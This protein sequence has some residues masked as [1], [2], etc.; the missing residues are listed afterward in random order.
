[1]LGPDNKPPLSYSQFRLL[2]LFV[3]ITVFCITNAFLRHLGLRGFTI[4]LVG[5]LLLISPLI[6]LYILLDLFH[7][8]IDDHRSL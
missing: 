2:E 1:M 4:R 7:S 8:R 3:F 6:P 5:S